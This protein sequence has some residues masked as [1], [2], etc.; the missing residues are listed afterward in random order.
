MGFDIVDD[1]L[2]GLI[3]HLVQFFRNYYS[4]FIT[5]GQALGAVMAIFVVAG[6]AYKVMVKQKAFDVLAILRPVA[7]ALVL[8]Q[9]LFF[10]DAIGA[11]P[12]LMEDYSH[13]VFQKEQLS[14][15]NLR[16]V[17]TRAAEDVK[18]RVQEAKASAQVAEKQLTDAS[19]WEKFANWG[20]DM[21]DMIKDQIYSFGTVF[22]AEAN[23]WL[24]EWIMKIGEFFWQIQVYLLFFIKETFAGILVLTGPIT[25]G[26]SVLPVWKD[27]WSQ[28]ITRYISILLYGFI[29]YFVLTAAIQMVKYGVQMDIQILNTANSTSEAFA[30]YTKSSVVTAL[31]HFVTLIVGGLSIKM[32][33][34]VATWIIPSSAGHAAKEFVSGAYHGIQSAAGKGVSLATGG[35]K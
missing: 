30:A 23:Q 18:K 20:P 16:E 9:W 6:E 19:I 5:A 8:S 7:I 12:R 14:V 2:L 13:S 25:F 4:N 21:M 11:I 10:A 28:W 22:Q 17:R 32:V 1:N 35:K 27:A 24:E 26:L 3:N 31:Y 15:T 33:P 34:E 29:G